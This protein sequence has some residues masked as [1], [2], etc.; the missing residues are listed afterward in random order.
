MQ[1]VGAVFVVSAIVVGALAS[2]ADAALSNGTVAIHN[3]SNGSVA[4][5]PLVNHQSVDIFVAGNSTLS[6]SSLEAAGFPSGATPIKVLE[7]ADLNGDPA[8]LPIKPTQ[9]D[10]TTIQSEAYLGANGSLIVRN[11][12]IYA[13]PDSGE[14]GPSNGTVCDDGANQCVLGLFSNQNDFTKPHLFSAP[15]QV[16]TTGSAASASGSPSG[17]SST[18]GGASSSAATGASPSVSVPPAT[19]ANT[20][21]PTLW[22]WLLGIGFV[23]LVAG[24]TLRY[25]RR[26][27]HEG[28]H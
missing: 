25:V 19:L 4:T 12:T 22:P 11:Y 21:G 9:C 14:L 8:N 6:R 3:S 13:L 15:F 10:P 28:K 1:L 18:S 20:G 26:P 7:C 24:S 27:A 23:L 16:K 17:S 5:N 2:H